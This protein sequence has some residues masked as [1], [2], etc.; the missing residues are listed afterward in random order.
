M[1]KPLLN[2]GDIG[3]VG[4]SVR[5]RCGPQRM[6]TQRPLTSRWRP[7]P[8]PTPMVYSFFKHENNFIVLRKA[9]SGRQSEQNPDHE[10]KPSCQV[11]KANGGS[12]QRECSTSITKH[13]VFYY[14]FC[15]KIT[16][17]HGCCW[18]PVY[19]RR[20][21]SRCVCPVELARYAASIISIT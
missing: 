11:G 19:S 17:S 10:A 4:E 8:G 13:L 21:V 12:P 1:P 6:H 2:L 5:C 20:V 3:I 7:L 16:F 14:P 9:L 15:R 18:H